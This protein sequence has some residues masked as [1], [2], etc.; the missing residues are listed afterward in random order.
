MYKNNYIPGTDK[1]YFRYSR[2]VQLS[3]INHDHPP[4]Q[5]TKK[6]N[7]YELIN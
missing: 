6:A 7:S 5:K 2:V 1:I 4:H 3:K